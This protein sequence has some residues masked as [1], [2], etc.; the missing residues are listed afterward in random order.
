MSD[1]IRITSWERDELVEHFSD[2]HFWWS[3]NDEQNLFLRTNN[4]GENLVA[5]KLTDPVK[6]GPHRMYTATAIPLLW[7]IEQSDQHLLE[8]L[9][10]WTSYTTRKQMESFLVT[11]LKHDENTA[12][13]AAV[14]LSRFVTEPFYTPEVPATQLPLEVRVGDPSTSLPTARNNEKLWLLGSHGGG[15]LRIALRNGMLQAEISVRNEISKGF[16][17]TLR[18]IIRPRYRSPEREAEFLF[19]WRSPVDADEMSAVQAEFEQVTAERE[20]NSDHS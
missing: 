16:G 20:A 15:W 1:S 19:G 11:E 4:E 17:H 3:G 8:L 5:V 9:S 7:N 6:T 2:Y 14:I 13:A 18:G 10:K 12:Y